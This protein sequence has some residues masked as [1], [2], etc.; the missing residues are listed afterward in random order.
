MCYNT[1][2]IDFKNVWFLKEK[3]NKGHD[4]N[5]QMGRR[6]SMGLYECVSAGEGGYPEA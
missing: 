2:T 1:E 4:G 3:L 6:G 5:V